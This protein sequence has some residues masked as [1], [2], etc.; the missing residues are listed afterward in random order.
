MMITRSKNVKAQIPE[1]ILKE[2]A[3]IAHNGGLCGLN[4]ADALTSIRRLTL[5]YWDKRRP[6]EKS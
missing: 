2:I 1:L 5:P 4:E 3:E 6:D